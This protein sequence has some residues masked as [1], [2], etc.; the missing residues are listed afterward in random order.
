MSFRGYLDDL[1]EAGLMDHVHE[2]TSPVQEVTEHSW[3]K[4]PILF[5]DVSG[6]KCCLNILGTRDL[7]ARALGIPARE[8]VR[9]LS[10]IGYQGPVREVDY[11]PF[12]E[13]VSLPDLSKL[14]ILTHF[15]GDGGPYI[16]SGVVV[17]L[18]EGRV[19]ACIHRLMVLGKDRWQPGWFQEDIPISS[20]RLPG[21]KARRLL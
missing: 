9:H 14:P 7:L 17:S 21:P 19:N 5:D 11:S 1:E 2:P 6:Y 20:M 18:Y 10:Q 8:M 12:M 3:G 16:T 15:S 13:K 4:G